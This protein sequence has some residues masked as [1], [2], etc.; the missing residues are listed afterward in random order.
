MSGAAV[1]SVRGLRKC[2]GAFTALDD[3]SFTVNRGEAFGIVGP[4]GAGKTTLLECMV[5][6]RFPDVGRIRVLGLDPVRQGPRLHK[7]IGVQLQESALPEGIKVEE[8][9]RLFAALNPRAVDVRSLLI[10]WGLETCRKARFS[11]LSGGQRQ[12]LFIAMT[13][14]NDPEVVFLDELTAGL[15]PEARHASWDLIDDLRE[16]GVTIV[17]VTHAMEE[18]EALCDRVAILDRGKVLALDTPRRLIEVMVGDSAVGRRG[19]HRGTTLEDAYFAITAD[20][21]IAGKKAWK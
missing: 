17:L 5:G 19:R 13:L 9:L 16:R 7:C 1:I 2:Y 3:V 8:A 10:S 15:D 4:N 18:A 14:V 21:E 20:A 12:R 6:L 11:A